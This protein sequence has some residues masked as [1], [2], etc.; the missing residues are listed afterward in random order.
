MITPENGGAELIRAVTA[1]LTALS[2]H[3]RQYYWVD[4][5]RLNAIYRFKTEEYSHDAVNKFNIYPEQI[6]PWLLDWIP[7][8]GGYFVGNV[9]PA[10]MDFR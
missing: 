2:F 6:P 4:L 7:D 8:K 9:Q 5:P 3:I 1:R 10:H